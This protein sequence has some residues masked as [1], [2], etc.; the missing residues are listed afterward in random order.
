MVAAGQPTVLLVVY[1]S[2][3]I[4]EYT[5]FHTLAAHHPAP[6]HSAGRASRRVPRERANARTHDEQGGWPSTALTMSYQTSNDY[7][8][9]AV[10]TRWVPLEP[11]PRRNMYRL[12]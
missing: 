4:T 7:D 9:E 1:I 3:Y 12:Y 8:F 5:T 6:I 11:A 10:D 2:Q